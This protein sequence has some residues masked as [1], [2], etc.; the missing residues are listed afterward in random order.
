MQTQKVN[1][2]ELKIRG[3]H[4]GADKDSS[5]LGCHTKAVSKSLGLLDAKIEATCSSE[6]L[7]TIYQPIWCKYPRRLQSATKCLCLA[8][9]HGDTLR[10]HN[11]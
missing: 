9:T 7:I 4:G 11:S 10:T 3:S 2:I 1:G 8:S 6:T 5:L